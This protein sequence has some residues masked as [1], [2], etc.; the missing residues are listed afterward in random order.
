MSSQTLA[1]PRKAST[2]T[3]KKKKAQ[4]S[5]WLSW[6]PLLAGIVITLVAVK[7]AEILPLMGPEGLFRLKLLYPF[8]LL[9]KQ[10]QFGLAEQTSDLWSQ[11]MLYA[12]W[13]IYG[14]YA[15][16]AMR[17]KPVWSV[18]MQVVVFHLLGFGLLWLLSAK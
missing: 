16:L 10:P 7:T 13:V 8:A 5:G 14:V 9:L 15:S 18:L 3:R 17:R 2:S 12:Q 6:W 1:R 11:T 4:R